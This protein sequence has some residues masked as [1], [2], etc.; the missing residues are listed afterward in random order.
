MTSEGD[1]IK[2]F[3]EEK[4]ELRG[5]PWTAIKP[6]HLNMTT[7]SD[8]GHNLSEYGPAFCLFIRKE[9]CFRCDRN[10]ISMLCIVNIAE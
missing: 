9:S 5:F 7:V 4:M 1:K 2:L 6:I 8:A 10:F 3:I